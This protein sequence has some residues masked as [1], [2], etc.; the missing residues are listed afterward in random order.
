[1]KTDETDKLLYKDLTFRIIGILFK[2]HNLLGNLLDEQYY[3]RALVKELKDQ[4][5]SFSKEYPVSIKYQGEN[6]GQHRLD[7]I[8]ED[9]IILETKTIPEITSK[10]MTQLIAYL[11]STG[12]RVGIL[13]NF[14]TQRLTY[15][16]VDNPL[17]R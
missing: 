5:I 10:S 13:A 15:R 8:I 16:R 12:L 3:Q 4:Q 9:K 1:M 6:I 7:F 14:R 11:K 2:V 17:T